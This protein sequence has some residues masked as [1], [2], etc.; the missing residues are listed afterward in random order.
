MVTELWTQRRRLAEING[1]LQGLTPEKQMPLLYEAMNIAEAIEDRA[2]WQQAKALQEKLV[3]GAILEKK[4]AAKR[5]TI[6]YTKKGEIKPSETFRETALALRYEGRLT[7]SAQDIVDRLAE[8]GYE[9]T[10]AT[11]KARLFYDGARYTGRQRN[12]VYWII[13]R[14]EQGLFQ[15]QQYEYNPNLELNDPDYMKR[16]I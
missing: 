7:F 6:A 9:T 3:Q 15:W 11:V 13:V 1:T 8:Q 12:R 10:A 2:V 14:N 4:T 16:L 5:S